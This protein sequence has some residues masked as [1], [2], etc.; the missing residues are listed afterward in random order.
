MTMG[1][2]AIASPPLAKANS[3]LRIKRRAGVAIPTTDWKHLQENFL[4]IFP[5]SFIIKIGA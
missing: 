2:T 5:P 3:V 1:W 4:Q